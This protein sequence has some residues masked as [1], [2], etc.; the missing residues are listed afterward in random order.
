VRIEVS[1]PACDGLGVDAEHRGDLRGRQQ[2][3]G[4]W[5]TCG[6][7]RGLSSWTSGAILHSCVTWCSVGSESGM[8]RYGPTRTILPSPPVTR[9]PPGAKVSVPGCPV[10]PPITVTQGESSDT[11]RRIAPD[12]E[13]TVRRLSAG[14][15]RVLGWH[16]GELAFRTPP[17]LCRLRGRRRPRTPPVLSSPARIRRMHATGHGRACTWR[18]RA[19]T[20]PGPR[21]R[22]RRGSRPPTDRRRARRR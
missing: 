8:S 7:V 9:R 20:R 13:I 15:P 14:G 19:R 10:T 16:R 4:L 3:L 1:L 12:S 6:H 11:Y 17:V 21:R 18:R 2:R 5:C 22:W